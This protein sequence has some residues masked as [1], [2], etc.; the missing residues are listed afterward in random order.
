VLR[1]MLKQSSEHL[2]KSLK[3]ADASKIPKKGGVQVLPIQWRKQINDPLSVASEVAEE[4]ATILAD[5]ALP[6]IAIIRTLISDLVLDGF[7]S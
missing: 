1:N 4:D 7:Y 5:I 6:G 3:P 2:R